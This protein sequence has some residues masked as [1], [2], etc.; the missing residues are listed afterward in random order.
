MKR[1]LFLTSIMFAV[2]LL[3]CNSTPNSS[4]VS[5]VNDKGNQH[6]QSHILTKPQLRIKTCV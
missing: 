4:Q 3:A 6:G 5:E 2:C 1:N